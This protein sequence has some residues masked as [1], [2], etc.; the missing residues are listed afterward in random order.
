MSRSLDLAVN[1]G[2]GKLTLIK[3]MTGAVEPDSGEI[4]PDRWRTD[5]RVL[6]AVSKPDE[7]ISAR[8]SFVVENV[9]PGAKRD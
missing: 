2:A 6:A 4:R 1:V 3:I 8:A 9:R 7:P 5:F